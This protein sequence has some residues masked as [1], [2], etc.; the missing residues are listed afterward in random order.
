MVDLFGHQDS[1]AALSERAD[2]RKKLDAIRA[3]VRERHSFVERIAVALY[4]NATDDVK[5]FIYSCDGDSPLTH[6]EV[7]L[8]E[9][10][11]LMEIRERR[12]PRVVNDMDLF[13]KG[14]RQHTR[15][16]NKEGYRASY[17]APMICEGVFFGFVFFN[18]REPD[19]FTDQLLAELDMLTHLITLMVYNERSNIRTLAATVKSALDM[20]HERDPET[21]SHLERM[22]RF[23]QLIARGLADQ[24]RF[25]DQFV[26]H[27]FLFS[28]LHD[29]GKISIP[30]RILLKPGKLTEDEFETMKSHAERGRQMVDSLLDNYGL[31]GVGYVGMLRNIAEY[32]H[33][34]VDGSGYPR[35]LRAEH[36]PIEARIVAVA[37]VFDALTSRRPYKD[38]WTNEAAF[39]KLR[40]MAGEK[41][42]WDCVR[43]LLENLEEVRR[44]QE[45]YAENAFG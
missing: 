16:I 44:I 9:A 14:V 43:V 21:G 38:P 36:I 20:T 37:D 22:A 40:E 26:E 11:S 6:Y 24:H 39:D 27:V 25:D 30:D 35:G 2:L 33:E 7:K 4:E 13:S 15:V 1:Y 3:T 29:L 5:T 31:D 23:A 12:R 18:S 10:P 32:H 34:A 45:K 41:L 17:T 19:V 42:D 8:S 28:P